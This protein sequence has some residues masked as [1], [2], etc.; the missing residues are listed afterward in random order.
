MIF[1]MLESSSDIAF[2]IMCNSHEPAQT[3]G[4]FW[5][6]WLVNIMVLPDHCTDFCG[7]ESRAFDVK[8]TFPEFSVI[9]SP[10]HSCVR[11]WVRACIH[12]CTQF[13]ILL[14][15]GLKALNP[16][17]GIG[18]TEWGA[19]RK[20]MLRLYRSLQ[21]LK[22]D[23]GS[24]VYGSAGKSYLWMLDPV[25]NQDLRLCL[26]DSER[27]LWRDCTFL[28]TNLAKLPLQYFQDWVSTE[29]SHTW[30]SVW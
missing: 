2:S 1:R 20:V 18:N 10:I 6:L 26:A 13:N 23:D 7:T 29:A 22:L 12:V 17:K 25:H 28:N 27:I 5:L 30:S 19:D 15:E 9:D 4:R 3:L 11:V 8:N 21:W 14:N 16:L 24:N